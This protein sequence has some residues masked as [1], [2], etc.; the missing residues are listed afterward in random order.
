MGLKR[1]ARN[2][3][4]RFGYELRNLKGIDIGYDPFSDARNRMENKSSP[5]LFDVGAN[6]G[7]TVKAMR[8]YFPAAQIHAFEP[9][10]TTFS[11]LCR[12]CA[13]DPQTK[14]MNCAVGSQAGV[15]ALLE[16]ERPQNSSFY[17]MGPFCTGAVR[18]ETQVEVVT[19]DQYCR[20]GGIERIDLLKSDTQGYELE[21]LKGAAEMIRAGRVKMIYLEMIFSDMYAGMPR[22]DELFRHLIDAGFELVTFYKMHFTSEQKASYTDALFIFRG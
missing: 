1:F 18:G 22:F 9:S 21:V 5:V 12:N 19:I 6:I 11:T 2:F 3:L 15:L 8:S 4:K 13:A 10:P 14:L 17:A 20:T 16:N 7:G